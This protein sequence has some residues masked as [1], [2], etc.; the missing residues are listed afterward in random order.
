MIEPTQTVGVAIVG[1]GAEC[2]AFM[3]ALFASRASRRLMRLIGIACAN[4][5]AA[6]YRYAQEKGVYTTTD[7]HNLYKFADLNIIIEL[8]G[9]SDVA[10]EICRSKP[11]H[12]RVMGH[13]CA[14]LLREVLQ[15][16]LEEPLELEQSRY[17]PREC[18]QP[19]SRLRQAILPT[20]KSM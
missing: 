7:Y 10:N 14:R 17:H 1:G 8:T 20:Q 11:D 15:V 18:P 9:R 16:E 19:C 13:D 2:K 12:V 3:D 4:P 6:G 5:R